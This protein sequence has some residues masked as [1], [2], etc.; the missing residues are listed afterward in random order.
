MSEP[1]NCLAGW[2]CPECGSYDEF[3]I[4]ARIS[5]VVRVS[6]DGIVGEVREQITEWDEDSWACC[7][8]CDHEATVED[9]TTPVLDKLAKL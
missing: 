4:A 9:F 7:C 3:K 8:Q 6:D 5:A 2:K 1:T